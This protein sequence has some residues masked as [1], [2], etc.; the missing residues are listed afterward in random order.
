[1]CL[2]FSR[3]YAI[4]GPGQRVT[5]ADLA[6]TIE[7]LVQALEVAAGLRQGEIPPAS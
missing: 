4:W 7:R 5:E 3:A 6:P 2:P 1:M